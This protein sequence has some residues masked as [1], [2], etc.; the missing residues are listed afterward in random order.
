ME[1]LF[2][3]LEGTEIAEEEEDDD[4]VEVGEACFSSSDVAD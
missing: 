3:F 1:A 4:V 2:R